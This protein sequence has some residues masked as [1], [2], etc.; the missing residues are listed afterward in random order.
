MF[1]QKKIQSDFVC[2]FMGEAYD[3]FDLASLHAEDAHDLEQNCK[4]LF[5]LN[6]CQHTIT[7]DMYRNM[8]AQV[9]R[10]EAQGQFSSAPSHPAGGVGGHEIISPGSTGD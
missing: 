7:Q 6:G 4:K 8:K 2:L 1:V 10:D 3:A 5:Q 9:V